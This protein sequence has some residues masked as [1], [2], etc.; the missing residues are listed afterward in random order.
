V[1]VWVLQVH[2]RGE[3]FSPSQPLKSLFCI[4]NY[5]PHDST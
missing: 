5:N 3:V 1:S 2:R 4:S